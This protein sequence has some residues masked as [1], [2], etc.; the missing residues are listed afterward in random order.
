MGSWLPDV[1]GGGLSH[2][3]VSPG[4]PGPVRHCFCVGDNDWRVWQVVPGE[5][6]QSNEAW[7][8]GALQFQVSLPLPTHAWSMWQGA[9]P[10]GGGRLGD[11][12]DQGFHESAVLSLHH[13]RFSCHPC[14]VMSTAHGLL[15]TFL[16]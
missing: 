10:G 13:E 8:E 14:C 16:L 3:P 11:S 1:V 2:L 4:P 15:P 9:A 5:A 6:L 12:R 7:A